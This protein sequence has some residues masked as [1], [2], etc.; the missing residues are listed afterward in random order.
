MRRSQPIKE[1][2]SEN[3]LEILKALEDHPFGVSYLVGQ[4]D[5]LLRRHFRRVLAPFGLTIGQYTALSVFHRCGKLS[6]AKLAERTMVSPQAANEL[7]KV[8]KRNGW[9]V[10]NP[11]P[12][13]GRIIHISLTKEGKKLLAQSN[14]VIAVL[15]KEM[16]QH[17]NNEE[18]DC[19]H[20]N[21]RSAVRVL[22]ER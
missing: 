1:Q 9:I 4:L 11:D 7:V 8:M 18:I 6:N 14:K 5:R 22:S 10:R 20:G 16:L 15:E 3:E 19:F 13:H 2:S 21:L 17:L 12:N